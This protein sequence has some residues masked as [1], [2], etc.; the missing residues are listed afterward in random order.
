MI[1]IELAHEQVDRFL[2]DTADA[3]VIS[4]KC[5]DYVDSKQWTEEE[6]KTLKARKQAT[7]VVNRVRPKVKGLVGL[8]NLRKTDPKAFPRTRKHEQSAHAI[9]DA[10]RFVADNTV[11]DETRLEVAE[12][13]FVEGYGGAI[14]DVRNKRDEVEIRIERTL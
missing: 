13:L 6:E 9:T 1:T 2:T 10:L 14:V 3:R 4:E 8:Y 7:I 5:R 11:F 12:E